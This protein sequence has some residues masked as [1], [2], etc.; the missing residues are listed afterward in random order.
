[1]RQWAGSPIG[2]FVG[3]VLSSLVAVAGATE[4]AGGRPV[5]GTAVN[6]AAGVVPDQPVLLF[7]FGAQ[8]VDGTIG[9]TK[10]I[11]IA[12]RV[13][14]EAENTYTAQTL[15][16]LKV[17]DTG[18]G[19]WH[20]ASALSMVF[21]QTEV[22]ISA[23]IP[24]APGRDLDDRA[25][26]LY[27]LA[28]TPIIAGYHFNKDEHLALSLRVW[29]PTGRYESGQLAN[30]SQNVWTFIPTL[31]YTRFMPKGWEA[32]T[33]AT[34]NISTR[35]SATDYQSAPLFTVDVLAT[36][37]LDAVWALGGIVGWIEQVGN[38]TGPLA[39]RLNGFRG[40]EV[41]VGPIVTYAT[42]VGALPLSTSLRWLETVSQKDR[43][44]RRAIYLSV[45]MPLPQ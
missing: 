45:S 6:P 8:A 34:L 19:A 32:S 10:Q 15:T 37:K 41:A 24:D 7:N 4:S 22:R 11:P 18:P 27:D 13:A 39:E 29:A 2:V 36:K 1:M 21:M 42:K 26:G 17:W 28:V 30:L 25:S 20:F 35:N 31:A 33:V 43:M 40:R 23:F 3:V 44:D 5:A 14:A 38:D 12:G 9:A 16:L